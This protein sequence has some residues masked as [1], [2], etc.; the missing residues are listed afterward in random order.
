MSEIRL[1]P[2]ARAA[3][4]SWS[5]LNLP[6]TSNVAVSMPMGR[7][8]AITNGM[9]KPMARTMTPSVAW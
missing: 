2:L 7:A 8:N 5:A 1:M 9:S 6:K 4:S 3:V